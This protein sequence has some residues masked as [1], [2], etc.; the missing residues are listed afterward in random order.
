[1]NNPCFK[2]ALFTLL[3]I[4][5]LNGCFDKVSFTDLNPNVAEKNSDSTETIPPVDNSS[6]AET[7]DPSVNSSPAETT[8]P[9]GNSSPTETTDP[10]QNSAGQSAI[11]GVIVD[12]SG[13][14]SARFLT[15]GLP[16]PEGVLFDDQ[17]I[18]VAGLNGKTLDSQWNPLSRWR[19]NGSVLHGALTFAVPDADPANKRRMYQIFKSDQVVTTTPLELTKAEVVTSGFDAKF[20]ITT[21]SGVVY[22]LS[23]ASLLD[24]SIIA[25][26]DY[27]HFSGHL[28]SEFVIGGNLLENG[29]GVAH[30]TLQGYF[31]IRAYN[32]PVNRVYVTFVLENTGVFNVLT[33]ITGDVEL[34]VGNEVVYSNTDFLIGADKRYPKR[35][36]WNGD[37]QFRVQF[38]GEYLQATKLVPEYQDLELDKALLDSFPRSIDW[39][40]KGQLEAKLH[41]GGAKPS[42]A[43]LDRWAVS[44]LISGDDRARNAMMAHADAYHWLVSRYDYAINPRDENTGFPLNL[45]DHPTSIGKGWGG[46]N[47]IAA[48]PRIRG[49]VETDIA[50]Q[51]NCAFVPYLITADFTYLE[52]CQFW[53]VANWMMERP[54]SHA[55]WPRSFYQGQTRSIAW[56]FRNMVFASIITPESHPLKQQLDDAVIFAIDSFRDDVMGTNGLGIWPPTIYGASSTANPDDVG[57]K[58]AYA[59]WQDDFVTW[60]MGYAVEAG[61]GKELTSSGVWSWKAKSIVER[62]GDA[63]GY[64][65]ADSSAYAIG[66]RDT[67]DGEIFKSWRDVYTKNHGQ[68]TC[69]VEATADAGVDRSALDY[70]AQIS[71]PISVAKSTGIVGAEEAFQ[72]YS[73]RIISWG[74]QFESA[75]EWAIKPHD[76]EWDS[77][78]LLSKLLPAKDVPAESSPIEPPPIL[79]S[80][81]NNT[82]EA[83]S[84]SI[85]PLDLDNL[86]PGHWLEVANSRL[87]DWELKPDDIGQE[88][89]DA[90]RGN[91]GIKGLIR[92]WNGGAYDT[93][94]DR[95][96]V[97]G[98][99]HADY[100][101]NE[102]YGFNINT[103]AWE[104]VTRP[105]IG[106]YDGFESLEDGAPN[107][108]H[109]YDGEVYIGG[110]LDKFVVLGNHRYRK[111]WGTQVPWAYDFVAN[112]WEQLALPQGRAQAN[113]MS[114]FDPVSG[115]L[116][117][118]NKDHLQYLDTSLKDI[119]LQQWVIAFNGGLPY[120]G[121]L[122]I[123]PKERKLVYLGIGT[124]YIWDISVDPVTRN[125][126]T[127]TG[128]AQVLESYYPGLDYNAKQEKLVAWVGGGDVYVLNWATNHWDKVI[129]DVD[130]VVTPPTKR[131][132]GTFGRFR[133]VPSKDVFILVNDATENVFFYKLP[134]L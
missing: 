23:A 51:P 89:Y 21:T 59:P 71:A 81:N 91:T 19:T 18:V 96:L 10:M 110:A 66:V 94:R 52:N 33:D 104:S 60:A 36:W 56:G 106:P 85:D 120:R 92:A 74:K 128:D 41:T 13:S 122:G 22:G 76:G 46:R 58:V 134:V 90:K 39:N 38:D 129:P 87:L 75:P 108:R 50:H 14:E 49:P 24:G 9:S 64:C 125:P 69:P 65:W 88:L 57:R 83:P 8:D 73:D 130:N 112:K 6:P 102:I 12:G 2:S 124:D 98:G 116:Y 115:R 35:F 20:S 27:T 63:A 86:K 40:E 16:L 114:A 126:S 42:I 118:N 131:Y 30:K 43:P 28:S 67:N 29:T 25:K 68:K 77:L 119:S 82:V 111:A 32:I 95:L 3:A 47:A 84:A 37:P 62:L 54:G 5:F 44:Y 79:T 97:W 61:Y 109:A 7:T 103:Y 78:A 100:A 53:G 4:V 123:D 26:Q 1:M 31:H 133:Y 107:S 48:G 127:V 117:I 101:G 132:N 105:S 72:R 34:M 113:T 15:I 11:T 17:K 93:K 80:P 55:S 70:G 121:T 99:G 45:T